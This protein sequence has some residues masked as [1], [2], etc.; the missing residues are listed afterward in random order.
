MNK[1]YKKKYSILKGG[2]E[3][4]DELNE[5]EN[6]IIEF[7]EE[8]YDDESEQENDYDDESEEENESDDELEE[9]QEDGPNIQESDD[10]S[11]E[12]QDDDE[13]DEDQD[14]EE[15]DEQDDDE[16]DEQD[17][18][19]DEDNNYIINKD[20]IVENFSWVDSLKII[21]EDDV[22]HELNGIYKKVIDK[23]YIFDKLTQHEIE[24][25]EN[26][27]LNNKPD[28]CVY[29]DYGDN[30]NN[31]DIDIKEK[32]CKEGFNNFIN[33]NKGQ[34]A[35]FLGQLNDKFEYLIDIGFI[36]YNSDKCMIMFKFD[37]MV[38]FINAK[39][40]NDDS[41]FDQIDYYME[42]NFVQGRYPGQNNFMLYNTVTSENDDEVNI[43]VDIDPNDG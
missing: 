42:C 3:P 14:D 12:D 23:Y 10:E 5:P 6:D 4:Q 17:E 26:D 31:F 41:K 35:G 20:N 33:K 38:F 29:I 34:Q 13:S 40:Y 1:L 7:Y 15:D 43:Y 28:S 32:N 37:E 30:M 11:D 2:V 9:Q 18:G 19:D 21:V 16:D 25:L 27:F 24:E 22:V 8:I 36:Y 39:N